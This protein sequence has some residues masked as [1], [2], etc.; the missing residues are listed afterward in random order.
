MIRC[1]PVLILVLIARFSF[2]QENI[3]VLHYRFHITVN[4][5]NDSI[6]GKAKIKFR[7]NEKKPVIALDLVNRDKDGK[8]MQAISVT[9]SNR[10]Q[11]EIF[12]HENDIL[13][14]PSRHNKGDEA[15]VVI[16]YKG[17]PANGLVI[18]KNKYGNRTFFADNWPNRGHHWLP[19]NEDP[20]DKASVEFI[21][22]AP[23]HYQVIGNG[24]QVEETNLPG[25]LKETHWK[26]EVPVS[27]KVMA[28]GIAEFAVQLAGI[29]DGC[30]PVYSW[31]YPEDRD[32]GFYDYGQAVE[33]LPYFIKHIGPYPYKKLANVE[34]KTMFGG[35]ENA[36]TIFYSEQ[37]IT[38]TRKSES[39]LAHEISHQWF[40]NMATEKSFA[41]LWLSEGFATYLTILYMEHKYGK[42][43]A[44]AMLVEDREQVIAFTIVNNSPVIDNNTDY[45]ELLNANSYQKGSWVLHMLRRELGDSVFWKSLRLFYTRYAGK[46]AL[47]EDYRKL[48]EEI[49]GKNLEKF[50][51]QWLYTPGLPRLNINWKY[52]QKHQK[53]LVSVKQEKTV[54]EFPLEIGL[55][56]ANGKLTVT[57][58]MIT[59]ATENFT[60]PVKQKPRQL[61]A[62]PATSLL[63]SGNV[64]EIK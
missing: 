1:I 61:V 52:D 2:A 31:V 40:G 58:F 62:D 41:H 10:S 5:A 46:T 44:Q 14:I 51:R 33:I 30:I 23:Q 63:F 3:D 24:I 64:S 53:V 13:Y 59:K 22:R 17:I 43:T 26:E 28:I 37:S 42:D 27:T 50:F 55:K 15:E 48:L 60:I 21:V 9:Y 49:S 36:N 32:Q 12:K 47:T 35:L 38:G 7:I 11:T 57:K 19:C 8:G 16:N 18:S 39:L 4:D 6:Y 29:V 34:S 54:F 20:A 56:D 25:G 45:M